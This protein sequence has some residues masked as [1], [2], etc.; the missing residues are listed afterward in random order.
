M[1]SS[2]TSPS[3]HGPLLQKSHFIGKN[4]PLQPP[5]LTSTT[6]KP[7]K[8]SVQSASKFNLWELMGGRGLCGGEESLEKELKKGISDP[9]SAQN[10]QDRETQ[11]E[12]LDVSHS[13]FTIKEE[14]FEKELLG[15]TGGFPGGEK[16]LQLFLKRNPPPK[17]TGSN[18]ANLNFGAS[19]PKA[20]EL[21]VLMPGM[22]AI[23]KNP[24]NPYYMYSGIIQRITD[25]KAGVLFEGGNWDKLLT[26]PLSDLERR[27]KGPPMVSPKSAVLESM[28]EQ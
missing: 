15:L 22:I 23:V 18:G 10:H 2:L 28:D 3:F 11:Q 17:K 1:A 5:I 19:K 25:G 12:G 4:L 9:I 20:P 8:F 16:G 21:P 7:C 14:A 13:S 6:P 27:E 26:F 24:N